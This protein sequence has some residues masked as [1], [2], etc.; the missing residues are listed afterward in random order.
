M[1]DLLKAEIGREVTILLPVKG[2]VKAKIVEVVSGIA[3][4]RVGNQ[5]F[6]L[7]AASVILRGPP[8]QA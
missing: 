3:I 4:V 7:A 2:E 5:Q 6:T 8:Y 1:E